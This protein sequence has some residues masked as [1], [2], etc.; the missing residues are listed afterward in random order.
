MVSDRLLYM[1][2]NRKQE[3]GRLVSNLANRSMARGWLHAN[4]CFMDLVYISR[5]LFGL[6]LSLSLSLAFSLTPSPDESQSGNLDIQCLCSGRIR[7]CETERNHR[8]S[9]WIVEL[10]ACCA[11]CRLPWANLRVFKT[12]VELCLSRILRSRKG[13]KDQ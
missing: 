3:H 9:N 5:S 4:E 7:W 2:L 13:S 10:G 8:Q 6:F 1:Q 12:I 11:N